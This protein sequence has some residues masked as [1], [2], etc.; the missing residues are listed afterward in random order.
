MSLRV[1]L[2]ALIAIAIAVSLGRWQTRRADSKIALQERLLDAEQGVALPID[3]AQPDVDALIWHRVAMSGTWL[4]Q[5]VVYLDNRPEGDRVGFYV[6][7]PLRLASG[8]IVL[9]N[10][11]W[12]P[13]DARD[14]TLIAPFETPPGEVDVAGIAMP[15]E[16]RFLDLGSAKPRLGELWENFSYDK[17]EAASG[18]V[19]LRL[20]VREDNAT[21]D[22]LSRAW[23]DRGAILQGQID[24]H[25]GYEFQW[26][27][28]A[29]AIVGLVIYWGFRRKPSPHG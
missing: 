14:R 7:M 4:A 6:L 22:G 19:P 13:R 9:V 1:L 25:H 15:D 12:L 23:P 28:M 21:L 26:Y 5:D 27:A 3:R 18:L 29:L 16:P 20:I 8:A 17:F 2:L 10:R 11:G 24:R